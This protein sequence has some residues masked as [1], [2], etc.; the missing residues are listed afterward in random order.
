[1]PRTGPRSNSQGV[2]AQYPPI[3][4]M[5]DRESATSCA[6]SNAESHNIFRQD[7]QKTTAPPFEPVGSRTAHWVEVGGFPCQRHE[8]RSVE[9][10]RA[11]K[12]GESPKLVDTGKLLNVADCPPRVMTQFIRVDD[13][14]PL[15]R[16]VTANLAI[17]SQVEPKD[18]S[19]TCPIGPLRCAWM[20]AHNRQPLCAERSS[21]GRSL[22]VTGAARSCLP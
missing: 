9:E 2:T 21:V 10:L 3:S 1:M 6:D 14:L 11:T 15:G 4:K 8:C 7:E 22:S 18:S 16:P 17:R 20:P 13:D 19:K 5:L 12:L